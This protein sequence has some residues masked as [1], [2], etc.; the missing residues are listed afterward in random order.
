MR[1]LYRRGSQRSLHNGGRHLPLRAHVFSRLR[2][3]AC[4][5][6]SARYYPLNPG[7]DFRSA[8][9]TAHAEDF[10]P[11]T[12][13]S[14][15]EGSR[16]RHAVWLFSPQLTLLSILRSRRFKYAIP[17]TT[18]VHSTPNELR[19]GPCE[20]RSLLTLCCPQHAAAAGS[21]GLT[22]TCK[23]IANVPDHFKLSLVRSWL[24]PYPWLCA[25]DSLVARTCLYCRVDAEF[26]ICNGGPPH[27]RCRRM[28]TDCP[29]AVT[30]LPIS[31]R[32]TQESKF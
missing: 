6:L 29:S 31:T 3:D 15:P 5:Y 14:T 26:N 12:V 7:Y 23:D 2:T 32:L 28:I 30:T 8:L 24:S 1:P 27:I 22:F 25:H 19:M 13:G 4:R 16:P 9:L 18:L 11:V 10:P 20:V 21:P 17:G